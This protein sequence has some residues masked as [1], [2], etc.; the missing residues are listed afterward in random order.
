M[1]KLEKIIDILAI[2]PEKT[3]SFYKVWE[4]EAS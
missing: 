4:P 3:L 1:N 2:F